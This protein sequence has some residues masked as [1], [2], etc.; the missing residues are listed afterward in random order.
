MS[1]VRRFR[2][3]LR[4]AAFLA[5]ALAAPAA[6]SA[7]TTWSALPPPWYGPT[8]SGSA[9]DAP[10]Y[11]L[12]TAAS[13]AV[14]G[15]YA[16]TVEATLNRLTVVDVRDPSRPAVVSSLQDAAHMDTPDWIVVQ[17][18]LAYVSS[19]GTG[20]ANLARSSL[21][22]YDISDPLNPAFVGSVSGDTRLYGAY[23]LQVVGSTAY[24]A[25]QGCVGGTG[26]VTSFPGG[27]ALTIVDVSDP[28]QPR[29]TGSV[30]KL[31]ETQ[32]LDSITVVGNRAY[33][34]AFYTQRLT[35]FDVSDPANPTILGSRSDYRLTYANDVQVKGRYAYVVDQSTTAAR[36][37]VVDV[38]DPTTMPITGS[39][40][41]NTYLR[42]AYRLQINS[43]F[44]FV[45]A[46]RANAL[47]VVDLSNPAAPRVVASVS[48]PIALGNPIGLYLLG[49]TA[50]VAAYCPLQSGG[51]CDPT[52][53]GALT[54][55]DV[56]AFG[57]AAP[58]TSITSG[59]PPVSITGATSFTF[60]ATRAGASFACMLDGGAP[61]PCTS[62]Q[63]Y[64]NLAPGNHTFTV[65]ATSL[66][67]VSDPT[68]AGYAWTVDTLAPQTT[69]TSAP[70]G[71]VT[72]T[73]ATID[74]T[75]DDPT[76]TFEC[77][78]D[79]AAWHPCS[80]PA[81]LSGLADGA[82]GF[83]VRATAIGG[84]D[85]TPATAAWV[86]DSTAP[87]ATATTPATVVLP[88]TVSFSEAVRN[89]TTANVTLTTQGAGAALG[90]VLACRTSANATVSC[91]SGPVAKA[92]LT[93]SVPL[94]AG[95]YYTAAQ[96]PAGV[97]AV[98]DLAGNSATPLIK[99]F[100]VQP[101]VQ[102]SSPALTQAWAD[103]ADGAALGGSYAAADRTGASAS[104][105]F[106]G[107]T[108]AWVTLTGPAQG[109]ADVYLDGKLTNS[110]DQNASSTTYGV[111][112]TYSGL[113]A[114]SH[115]IRIVA[116]GTGAVAI[117]GFDVGATTDPAP[118]LSTRWQS[119]SAGGASGG[120]Y[121][122][123][124]LAGAAVSLTFRGTRV[125]WT[126]RTG[127]DGG[128]ADVAIDGARVATVDTYSA[129]PAFLVKRSYPVP[130]GVHTITITVLGQSQPASAGTL[131]AVDRFTVG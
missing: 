36:L 110:P 65:T 13:V 69:I 35:S 124:D 91:A 107:P 45:D 117:D 70:S 114:A 43:R 44:A 79:G 47:S 32:H 86:V 63:D 16:F 121:V 112:R 78:L 6:A 90:A 21:S 46:P 51:G 100:R 128:L 17:G 80:A 95:Q 129:A 37:T 50:Y 115:T 33:G 54:T 9:D 10:A 25:A 18:S 8:V 82:H 98:T 41:D 94:T 126:T 76:A 52:Q 31:P 12:H 53:H 62:P 49:D 127:P 59:P 24:I 89:V 11:R 55:V 77:R 125:D 26:C 75:S 73:S 85:A 60:T 88:L 5:L 123:D 99:T 104:Y 64:G 116:R 40:L 105:T 20:N 1:D 58:D 118:T 93:P 84:T 57:D 72:A 106:S 81:T 4:L 96:S 27:N 19:K 56:S 83:D 74:F 7:A 15:G 23:G 119:V 67:G 14:S 109:S 92:I 28:T 130:D 120:H 3:L 102:E 38:T 131:V 42:Y 97:P 29:I 71:S 113:T 101:T 34:T 61:T 111:R 39:V 108:V 22:I 68:P 30:S 66:A 103:T 87:T 48:D 2:V 122:Q